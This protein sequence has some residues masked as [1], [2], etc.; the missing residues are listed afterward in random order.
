MYCNAFF[1]FQFIMTYFE[2]SI[3]H[4]EQSRPCKEGYIYIPVAFV[5]VLYLVYLVECWHSCTSL[6]LI[7]KVCSY[8]TL[9]DLLGRMFA[10]M[11]ES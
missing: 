10:F 11:Y 8:Y 9:P 1:L 2:A 4:G 3:R 7:Y 5:I 6:E